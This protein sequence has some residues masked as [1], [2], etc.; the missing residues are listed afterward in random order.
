MRQKSQTQ[1]WEKKE[2]VRGA[3]ERGRCGDTA[4]KHHFSPNQL[5]SN[6]IFKKSKVREQE[7]KKERENKRNVPEKQTNT[8]KKQTCFYER[9]FQNS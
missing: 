1:K 6:D 4:E 8:R 2:G 7:S 9:I 5:L 3:G